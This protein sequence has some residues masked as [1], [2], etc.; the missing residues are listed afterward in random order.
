MKNMDN[1]GGD[2]EI[3]LKVYFHPLSFLTIRWSVSVILK[4]YI[5]VPNFIFF[6]SF[7]FLFCGEERWGHWIPAQKEKIVE[8]DLGHQNNLFLYQKVSY[9]EGG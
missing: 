8:E 2:F 3:R 7:F 1:I 6:F 9:D 4:T 5:L